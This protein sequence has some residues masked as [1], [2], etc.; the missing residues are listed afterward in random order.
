VPLLVGTSRKSFLGRVLGD[1]AIDRDDA[2]LATSVWSFAHGA[3]VVRVHDVA[4][5][6]RAVDLLDVM[7]RAA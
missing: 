3:A 7:E 6:R 2:T 4:A 5:S 1:T